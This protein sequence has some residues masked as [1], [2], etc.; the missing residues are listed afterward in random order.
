MRLVDSVL[1]AAYTLAATT[2]IPRTSFVSYSDY[3]PM[4][5]T[6]GEKLYVGNQV[7]LAAGVVFKAEL[8]EY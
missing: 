1:M 4:R 6:A 8:M 7:A 3:S 5:L 2:A